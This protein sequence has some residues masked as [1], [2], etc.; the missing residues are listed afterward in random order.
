MRAVPQRGEDCLSAVLP[1]ELRGFY[2]LFGAC[3]R[4]TLTG[5]AVHGPPTGCT[6]RDFVGSEEHTR[7]D[8]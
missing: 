8:P 1:L 7:W 3:S 2:S 6:P 5:V 4:L